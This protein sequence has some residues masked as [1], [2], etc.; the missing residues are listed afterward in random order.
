MKILVHDGKQNCGIQMSTS[1]LLSFLIL[2]S[3]KITQQCYVIKHII[4]F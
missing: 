3:I 2:F 4:I 1:V